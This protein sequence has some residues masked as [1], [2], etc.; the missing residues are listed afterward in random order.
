MT[1]AFAVL[2]GIFIEELR[3]A[4]FEVIKIVC[5]IR[6]DKELKR[7]ISKTTNIYSLFELLNKNP[8][9]LNWMNVDYLNIMALA[10]GNTRLQGILRDYYTNV[11]LSK[12]LGEIW[13]SLPS[14]QKTRTKYYDKL[15]AEFPDQNPDNIK[16]QDLQNYKPKLAKKM[17]MHLQGDFSEGESQGNGYVQTTCILQLFTLLF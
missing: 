7:K 11:V 1:E 9:Y 2:I 4:N 13:N 6:F 3:K 10:A 12:T 16:V 14:F 15:R 8:L 5:Q 17:G